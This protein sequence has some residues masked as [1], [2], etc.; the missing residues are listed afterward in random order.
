MDLQLTDE[1]RE[2]YFSYLEDLEEDLKNGLLTQDEFN[3]TLAA[4]GISTKAAPSS[5]III[6]Y[7]NSTDQP[8]DE[9]EQISRLHNL[10]YVDCFGRGKRDSDKTLEDTQTILAYSNDEVI[11]LADYVIEPET[12][13]G[14]YHGCAYLDKLIVNPKSRKKGIGSLLLHQVLSDVHPI[15]GIDR[16]V[17]FSIGNARQFYQLNGFFIDEEV[18]Y[19]EGIEIR[20]TTLPLTPK[21]YVETVSSIFADALAAHNLDNEELRKHMKTLEEYA[22]DYTFDI[23]PEFDDNVF[24]KLIRSNL[25]APENYEVKL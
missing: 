8:E 10:F 2:L 17:L 9:D 23:K 16:L 20:K 5:K 4:L 24:F 7:A 18:E 11:G 14:T 22:S 3:E 13:F 1:Q 19:K 15:E 21:A 25:P 6:Q 12:P